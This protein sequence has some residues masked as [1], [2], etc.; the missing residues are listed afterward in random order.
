[1]KS[2]EIVSLVLKLLAS[3]AVVGITTEELNDIGEAEILRLGGI[4]IN[5]GYFPTWAKTAFPSA[6]CISINEELCHGIPGQRKLIEGDIV[7]FDLGVKKDDLC[8][9]AA[10]TMGIGELS[11]RDERLLYYGRK[12][13]EE[14]ISKVKAGVKLKDIARAIELYAGSRGYVVNHTFSGHGIGKEMHEK[15]AI[16]H[17]TWPNLGEEELQVG[18]MI[19]LEPILTY[20][21]TFGYPINDWEWKTTD[22][23][24]SCMFEHQIEV[25]ENGAR[26]LTTHL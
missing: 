11:N 7:T 3:K 24:K 25:L 23:K 9:D 12:T 16:P 6:I 10:F 26:I 18:Q 20:K 4:S 13:L 14:G 1:M 22:G 19:C 15:P 17:V 2:W 21:D 5:K 8:G